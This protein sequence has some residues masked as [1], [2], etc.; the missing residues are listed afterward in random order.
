MTITSEDEFDLLYG[1]KYLGAAD[2]K[3][4]RLP[5]KSK[6]PSF[7][8]TDQRRHASLLDGKTRR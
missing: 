2:L 6:P 8:K 7:R 1:S 5:R 4:P 3:A